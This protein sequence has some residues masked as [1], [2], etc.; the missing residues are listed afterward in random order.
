MRFTVIALW[1]MS[2]LI[3]S[4]TEAYRYRNLRCGIAGK[5]KLLLASNTYFQG[6][7]KNFT[8]VTSPL[9]ITTTYLA[10]CYFQIKFTLFPQ[11]LIRYEAPLEK[12]KQVKSDLFFQFI[13]TVRHKQFYKQLARQNR[14]LDLSRTLGFVYV[15]FVQG[16]KRA[17]QI[18]TYTSVRRPITN[19]VLALIRLP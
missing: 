18:S 14:R 1:Y 2:G 15:V 11:S 8:Y 6:L 16:C 10:H 17:L 12:P 4:I 7:A 9:L 13:Q 5:R 3:K 19:R